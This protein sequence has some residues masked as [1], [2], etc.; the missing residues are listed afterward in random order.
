MPTTKVKLGRDQVITLDGVTLEGV[1]DVDVDIDVATH[2]VTSWWHGWKS[3][4]PVAADAT[5]R[6]LIYWEEN[7]DD[8]HSKLNKHPP[9][10]MT[11]AM[12]NVGS[13]PC[14]P[15]KVAVKEPIAGVVAWEVTLK[16]Y[17]YT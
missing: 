14:V 17:T 9:E 13:V 16:L 8:F 15:V 11:L 2:D 10:P 5:I 7:Y 3:T 6:V 12:S 4:L 1:R